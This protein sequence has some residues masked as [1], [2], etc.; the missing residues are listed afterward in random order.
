MA[1]AKRG[2]PSGR[3]QVEDGAVRQV[4]I[5]QRPEFPRDRR[6]IAQQAVVME[7]L[8]AREFGEVVGRRVAD[9]LLHRRRDHA[10]RDAED[11]ATRAAAFLLGAD[12]ARPLVDGGLARAVADQP[13]YTDLAAPEPMKSRSAA[14]GLSCSARSSASPR[15][16][17]AAE[18]SN[19]LC[20]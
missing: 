19:T 11:A 10:G 18:F 20:A 3:A 13:S 7:R 5:E 14:A 2:A 15:T 17:G 16:C 9:L 8:E 1:S 6:R 12:D 4:A